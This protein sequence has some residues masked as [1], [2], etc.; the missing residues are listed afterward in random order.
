MF[1]V[2]AGGYR[3][4][5]T[6]PELVRYVA[7]NAHKFQ[8]PEFVK[9][10]IPSFGNGLFSSNGKAHARQKRMIGPAFA[11]KNLQGFSEIFKENVENLVKVIFFT[12][13]PFTTRT[14]TIGSS[15]RGDFFGGEGEVGV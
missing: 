13:K 6:D 3:V 4:C 14:L 10:Q 1:V 5:L 11:A 15:Y 7:V 2:F 8:R 12:L 9:Q